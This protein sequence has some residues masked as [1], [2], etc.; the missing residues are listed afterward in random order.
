MTQEIC[1]VAECARPS[2][3]RGWC[4]KHYQ[5]WVSHGNPETILTNYGMDTAER[6]WS[7]V[8]RGGPDDCWPWMASTFQDGR[9]KFWLDGANR[10]ASRVAWELENGPITADVV[11]HRCDNPPCCNPAHLVPGTVLE[12]V[13]DRVTRGRGARGEAINNAVLT[14]DR[15]VALLARRTEGA[16]YGRLAAEFGVSAGAVRDIVKRRTWRHVLYSPEP[17]PPRIEVVPPEDE[18]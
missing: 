12:N 2:R 7:K 1:A 16:S 14:E 15:V 17:G 3:K 4:G 13:M 11:R 6:F 18:S 10:V 9:G 8:D 5:R